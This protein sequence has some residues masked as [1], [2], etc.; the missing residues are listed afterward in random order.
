MYTIA[1][2]VDGGAGGGVVCVGTSEM[3]FASLVL[4]H[5]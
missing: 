1:L 2:F 4:T 5:V 3:L